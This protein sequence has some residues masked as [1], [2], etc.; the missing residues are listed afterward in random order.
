[1]IVLGSRRNRRRLL[2]DDDL[3]RAGIDRRN[4]IV[5]VSAVVLAMVPVATPPAFVTPAGPSGCLLPVAAQLHRLARDGV[6]R[7]LSR[8]VTV[9]VDVVEP[10]ATT[11]GRRR[12]GGRSTNAP[13]SV[14]RVADELPR[15]AAV[16]RRPGSHRDRRR[17]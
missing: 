15:S 10:S 17:R 9:M 4:V 5:F 12:R 11:L 14:A 6:C 3:T 8:T 1:V 16:R 7:S 2:R 13:L